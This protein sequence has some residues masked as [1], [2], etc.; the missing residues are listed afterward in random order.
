MVTARR[1]RKNAPRFED[2]SFRPCFRDRGN[3]LFLGFA[4]AKLVVPQVLGP[5]KEDLILYVNDIQVKVLN[6]KPRID[7][8]QEKGRDGRWYSIVAPGSAAT[9]SALTE[10]IF[11]DAK[12]RAFARDAWDHAHAP[13]APAVADD[14]AF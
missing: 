14:I 2:I 13:T 9:R 10:L 1:T 11:A 6:G 8:P 7:L 4:S 12:I 5:D 3:C